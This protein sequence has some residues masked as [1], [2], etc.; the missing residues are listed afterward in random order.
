MFFVL[1]KTA[2]LLLWPSNLLT[3]LAL[4]GAVLL[5]TRF[6]SAGLRLLIASIVLLAVSGFSPLGSLLGHVLEDRFPAWDYSRGAPDGIVV[7]GGAIAPTL[8]RPNGEPAVNA[9]AGRIIAI[10]RLANEFPNARIVYSGGDAS[11]PATE[12][13]ETDYVYPLLDSLGVPRERVL[14]ESRSRNTVENA[15]FT[16]DLVNPKPSERWLL[17]TSARHMPRAVGCFRRIGFSVEAYP[18]AWQ[19]RSRGNFR[20]WHQMS[21]GLVTLDR[22]SREWLGLFIYWLSGH[23]SELL[24]GPPAS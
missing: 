15:V 14:L 6:R 8:S 12:P 19:T 13:A 11:L 1:S 9:E 22:A 24:P 16:K 2:A 17:V 10:A 7:L 23:T 20:P 5:A 3:I 18:V 4:V 21:N